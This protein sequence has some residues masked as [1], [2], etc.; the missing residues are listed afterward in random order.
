MLPSVRTMLKNKINTE[1]QN[2]WYFYTKYQQ[3]HQTDIGLSFGPDTL[4]Q[5]IDKR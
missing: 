1:G 3:E 5:D 4:Y 2:Q